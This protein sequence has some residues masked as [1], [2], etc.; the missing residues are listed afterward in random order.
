MF[1]L[2]SVFQRL[3]NAFHLL[4]WGELIISASHPSRPRFTTTAFIV[5]FLSQ[6]RLVRLVLLLF[7]AACGG[8]LLT[9]D[10]AQ[11]ISTNVVDL[12]PASEQVPELGLVRGFA[13]NV[14]SRVMLFALHDRSSPARPPRPAAA[15][16]ARHLAASP[17]FAEVVVMGD[18]DAG[19]SLGRAV[20]A[21]RLEWLLPTWLGN[22]HREFAQTGATEPAFSRWLAERAAMDLEA[23]LN[24]PEAT[25]MQALLPHDPLLLVP[26]LVDRARFLTAGDA[27]A[28]GH[29][30]VW[31]R[32][33]ESP[34]T[35]AGQ[36]P[37]FA[38]IERAL[39]R[40]RADPAGAGLELKWS[41]VNRFAAA[42]RARIQAE[43]AWL[44][45][46][47]IVAVLGVSCLFV[48]RIHKLLHVVPIIL[49]SILG[50]WTIST[51]VFDRLHILVFVIGSLLSGVTIDYG[52]YIYMQPAQADE[53]YAVRL[54]RIIKP[55]LTS[56]LTNVI[57][58]SLL[59]FSEL[60]LIRQI[61]VFV[62][63]GML[64]ALGA[65]ILYFAQ[66][67][68]AVLESRRWGSLER[69]DPP[70]WARGLVRGGLL[71]AVGIIVTGMLRVTWYDDVRELDLP[72]TE[73]Q[74]NDTELR[75]RFGESP[76]RG[77]FLTHGP[78]LAVARERL[79]SYLKYQDAAGSGVTASTGLLLPTERDWQAF[80][81]RLVAL[82]GFAPA[83]QAALEQRGFT[84]ESFAPFFGAWNARR[85][86]PPRGEYPAVAAAVREALTGPLALLSNTEAPPY[87]FL[88]M[89]E[90]APAAPPPAE[91]HT[92]GINQLQ[93]LNALFTRYRASALRLSMAGLG[94]LMVS[95]FL[96]YPPRLALRIAVI[97]AGSCLL[98]FALLGLSGYTLNL[99]H[100]LGA[101]LGVCLS[102]DY[103]IF[104]VESA[105]SGEAPPVPVRLSAFGTAASFGVL[106]FSGIPVIHALGMTV[107]LIVLTA[108]AAVEL[109]SLVRPRK[110]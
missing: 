30:L 56:C 71:L 49:L 107:S 89:V 64:C 80:P 4:S 67:P 52:F 15:A 94:L 75:R 99:F 14:Q 17:A 11:K 44:N 35:E 85:S 104:S 16:F 102:H 5:V 98:T 29:A 61:G 87:W 50:A 55:L 54:R 101:F 76:Q 18:A 51:L 32:I 84:T 46:A 33:K 28:G 96:I 48:R 81:S 69:R 47:S 26:T 31:T 92:I 57:G 59:I 70:G 105:A 2:S 53:P 13:T 27:A 82:E 1:I 91:F 93:S 24:R 66:L 65:S 34:F 79:E 68:Q 43:I 22:R 45:T 83:F 20:F 41:G 39:A 88:S 60:P 42:S 86:E 3:G 106:A 103:A 9:L 12:I 8:W 73:L 62:S 6:K 10:H 38:E 37:V 19:D 100:L 78:T 7:A 74:A 25:A 72:A 95:V 108:L 36:D 58:F 63:A 90:P 77:V 23:F 21:N 110:S 109:E 40:V 97:P